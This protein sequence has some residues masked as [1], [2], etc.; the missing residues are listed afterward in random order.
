MDVFTNEDLHNL[1]KQVEG[2]L[3]R[4]EVD[5]KDTYYHMPSR[6]F[7]PSLFAWDSGYHAVAMLHIDPRKAQ[8]ELETLF[9][10]VAPDGHLPHETLVPCEATSR[11]PFKNFTRWLVQ[12]EYDSERRSH[13]VDPPSY[14]YAAE[15]VYEWT[16]DHGWLKR[17]WPDL[18]RSLDY[19]LDSRDL[20]GDGLVSIVH[21]WEA[22]TDLSPQLMPA[23]G[24]DPSRRS[25]WMKAVS[26]GPL[27][28]H[29]CTRLGWDIDAIK[30][31]NRFV[32]ED[33]T[34]NCLVVRAL[35]SAALL[36]EAVEDHRAASRYRS[37]A[38]LMSEAID[39]VLWDET[40]GCYYPRWD[41]KNPKLAKVKTAQSLL[42][43]FAGYC[44]PERCE[45]L[46]REHLK[47]PRRFWGRHLLPF[48]PADELAGSAPWVERC[49]W[50]GHCIWINFNWLVAVGLGDCGFIEEACQITNRT[51]RM[52]L[53]EGLWEFYDS[54]TGEG[55]RAREFNWPALVLDMLDRFGSTGRAERI[56]AGGGCR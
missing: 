48:N 12:W 16:R 4:N 17:I 18:S 31:A 11:S 25:H 37:R 42:P 49:L 53:A 34:M 55:K 26:A 28:Y 44:R 36:G 33:L 46:V 39:E 19:L 3:T 6:D 14:V 54:R 2:V 22:G 43:L 20:F 41:L 35:R 5:F 8:R 45:R 30:E 50:S 51:A 29:Y 27:L 56:G 40:E 7:Y 32:V 24:I 21:P 52:V 9:A 1:R 23:L 10:H 38:R 47:N 15:L 13:L